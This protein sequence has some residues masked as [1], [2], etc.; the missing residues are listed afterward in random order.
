MILKKMTV[1]DLEQMRTGNARV[2]EYKTPREYETAK[3]LCSRY[4]RIFDRR[5]S[6]S[7][8]HDGTFSVICKTRD[9]RLNS[10]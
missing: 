7:D 9:G 10:D 1:A 4:G 2:F 3:T 5:F 8:N 6:C